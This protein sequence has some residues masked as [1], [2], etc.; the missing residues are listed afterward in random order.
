MSIALPNNLHTFL[1][2]SPRV[3]Q[4]LFFY[5]FIHLPHVIDPETPTAEKTVDCHKIEMLISQILYPSSLKANQPQRFARASLIK[6]F[7]VRFLDGLGRRRVTRTYDFGSV[8]SIMVWWRDATSS[9]RWQ[10]KITNYY[11]ALVLLPF[12][13]YFQR[14]PR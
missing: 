7:G 12:L 14:K 9:G 10:D 11:I 5:T 6:P 4:N 13:A 2:F 1:T 3:Q 8:Q